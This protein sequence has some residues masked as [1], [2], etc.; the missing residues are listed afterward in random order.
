M[1]AL[2]LGGGGID[3]SLTVPLVLWPWV[4]VLLARLVHLWRWLTDSDRPH[5]QLR[6]AALLVASVL[7]WWIAVSIAFALVLVVT[8]EIP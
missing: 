2:L 3:A 1:L 8:G 4:V 7:L 6:D 5:A